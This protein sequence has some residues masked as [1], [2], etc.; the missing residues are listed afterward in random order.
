MRQIAPHPK[1]AEKPEEKAKLDKEFQEKE[2]TLEKKLVTE[3]K[4]EGRIFLVPKFGVDLLEK[5]RVD[6]LATPTP[7]PSPTGFP[8]AGKPSREKRSDAWRAAASL[9]AKKRPGTLFPKKPGVSSGNVLLS[10]NL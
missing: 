6:L 2:E 9:A 3:K 10:H 5:S 8:N 4:L 1:R 7:S